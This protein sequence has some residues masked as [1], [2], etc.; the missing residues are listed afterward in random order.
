VRA[1][2]GRVTDRLPA[3]GGLAVKLPARVQSTALDAGALGTNFP[4]TIGADM[5]L[6]RLQHRRRGGGRGRSDPCHLD[7]VVLEQVLVVEPPRV[8]IQL[9]NTGASV[10]PSRRLVATLV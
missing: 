3:I 1:H 4:K 10:P 5:D 6:R 8:V 2:H 7:E 9:E